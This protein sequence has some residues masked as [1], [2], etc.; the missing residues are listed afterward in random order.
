[1][2]QELWRIAEKPPKRE[3]DFWIVA[4]QEFA[5]HQA[6]ASKHLSKHWYPEEYPELSAI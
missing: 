4:D 1:M 5:D 2:R 3:T 6:Q